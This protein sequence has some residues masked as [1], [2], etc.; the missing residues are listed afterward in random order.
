[1]RV[2]ASQVLRM[3][4][5][6]DLH[7]VPNSALGGPRLQEGK[8]HCSTSKMGRHPMLWSSHTSRNPVDPLNMS[9]EAVGRNED[10]PLV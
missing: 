7:P 4:V 3:K 1:M 5:G 8:G 10:L 6:W 9:E 2:G